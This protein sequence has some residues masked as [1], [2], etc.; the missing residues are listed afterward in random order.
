MDCGAASLGM[1][2]RHFG[3][4]VSL[5]RIRQLCHTSRDGTSLKALCHAATELGP[6]RARAQ[7]LAAQ[8]RAH[9]V[10]RDHALGGQSLARALRCV[11]RRTCGVDDPGLGSR[12]ISREE[13]ETK[14]SGYAALFDYTTCLREGATRQVAARLKL[15]PFLQR[16]RAVLAAG[17]PARARRHCVLQL[18]FPVFTQVVV[19]QVIVERRPRLLQ[20]VLLAMGAA[21]VF[22]QLRQPRAA[23]SAL[24][25]PPYGSTQRSS[26]TSRD[27]S[28]RCR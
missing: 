2:C 15:R 7:G 1:I 26:I 20:A 17:A 18:L 19:D 3:R 13:F 10:A 21:L 22:T 25:L 24:A 9:A 11:A 27:R 4:K 14:W 12:K 5:S 8:S 16:P 6:R 23:I 28:S